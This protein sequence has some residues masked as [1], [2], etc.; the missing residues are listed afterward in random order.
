MGVAVFFCLPSLCAVFAS[1]A[2]PTIAGFGNESLVNIWNWLSTILYVVDGMLA[3][4]GRWQERV[5]LGKDAPPLC[6]HCRKLD[7]I[8][9]GDLMFLAGA[10]CDVYDQ[11]YDSRFLS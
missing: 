10:L 4:C 6:G 8:A 11:I 9:W 5:Q 7:Y 3:L 1:L 2:D